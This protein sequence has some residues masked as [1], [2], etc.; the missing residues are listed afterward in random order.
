MI[1]N[2]TIKVM[3]FTRPMIEWSS[4]P[5]SALLLSVVVEAWVTLCRRDILEVRAR[6]CSVADVAVFSVFR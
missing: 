4:L 5:V 2:K 1:N 6:I 3:K